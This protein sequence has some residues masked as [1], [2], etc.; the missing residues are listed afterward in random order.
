MG[1][2]RRG[3]K[4]LSR[5]QELKYENQKLRRE[6]SSL[7]KQLA[8]IDLDRYSHVR[9]MIEEHLSDNEAIL[10]VEDL[11]NSMKNEWKCHK[12]DQGHLEIYKYPRGPGEAYYRI[13]SRAPACTNRTISQPWTPSVK[14]IMRT[15]REPEKIKPPEKLSFK[16][17]P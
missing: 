13:C 16:K 15:E 11:S 7:R 14:G 8:R 6:V 4:E 10:T 9:D 5:E 3:D 12:C 2:A 1:K 17:K